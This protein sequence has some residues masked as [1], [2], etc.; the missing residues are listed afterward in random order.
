MTMTP[1]AKSQLSTTI[2]GLRARLLDDLHHA[3]AEVDVLLV[4]LRE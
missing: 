1:E 4:E 2:R 3:V